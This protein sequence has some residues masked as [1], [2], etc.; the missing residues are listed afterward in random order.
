MIL[1]DEGIRMDLGMDTIAS[2]NRSFLNSEG[3][4]RQSLQRAKRIISTIITLLALI[5]FG[6]SDISSPSGLIPESQDEV[7][8]QVS[9]PEFSV[10][11]GSILPGGSVVSFHCATEGATL[12]YSLDGSNFSEGDSY[13]V[14]EPVKLYVK[15][16]KASMLDSKLVTGSYLVLS[17][18]LEDRSFP[19]GVWMQASEKVLEGKTV[20]Q[21]Y[22]EIGVNLYI[23]LWKWPAEDWAYS[24]YTLEV[25]KTLKENE[26]KAYAGND[27]AAVDWINAHPEYQDTIIGYL[28]GDEPDMKRNSGV[29]SEA[30][31][32]TPEAWNARGV[33]LRA[34]DGTRPIYANFGK[35]L[36]KDAWYGNEYGSTGSKASDFNLYLSPCDVVSSDLYG[37][38]DPWERLENHGIWIYGRSVENLGKWANGKPVYGYLEAS[39]P[40]KNAADDPGANWM[41]QRMPPSYVKPAVWNMIVHGADGYIFFCHDFSP[42]SAT[43]LGSYAALREP[44]MA[45]AIK[46]ANDSVFAFGAALK[47]PTIPGTTVTTDGGVEVM[48]IAKAHGGYVYVFAQGDGDSSHVDGLAVNAV[49]SVGGQTDTK[50]VKELTDVRDIQMANGRITDHFEPYELHIYRIEP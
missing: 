30:A 46:E 43:N 8:T 17:G 28:L 18:D 39:A 38:T 9:T 42:V 44:G 21:R 33:A 5:F 2:S 20:A 36:A 40:W 16:T 3:V 35:P 6:C 22:K 25:A 34:A 10:A 37:I 12:K 1:G 49:I 47:E 45:E 11:P 27:Q 13:A 14:T 29:A 19:V 41:F 32:N 48:A 4:K 7:I 23:G 26:L 15:A 50:T 31:A 24:G